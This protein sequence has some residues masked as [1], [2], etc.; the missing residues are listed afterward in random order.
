ML[1]VTGCNNESSIGKF[2]GL[3]ASYVP[4]IFNYVPPNQPDPNFSL[5]LVTEN[6]PYWV[7]SLLMENGEEI[8]GQILSQHSRV[9]L[10]GFPQVMP[11]YEMPDVKMWAKA[12]SEMQ[13]A[14]RQ[15]FSGLNEILDI[16]FTETTDFD[17][18]NVIGIASS[19]QSNTSGF[20]YF[21]NISYLVA[22]SYT[23]LTLPTIYS[24]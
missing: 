21:P 1:F 3:T 18:Q 17:G 7:N 13:L 16:T 22:V 15:L 14:T 6:K 2:E 4:P 8:V 11:T 24:V 23:H 9:Y 12:N 19:F 5:L 20:S 10:Y